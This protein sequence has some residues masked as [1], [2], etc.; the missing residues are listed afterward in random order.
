MWVCVVWGQVCGSEVRRVGLCGVRRVG[1]CVG[2]RRV[3]LCEVRCAGLFVGVRCV[4]L[5]GGQVSRS[6]FWGVRCLGLCELAAPTG[7][8]AWGLGLGSSE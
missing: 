4:G 6:V 8:M 1:L 5:W 2:V 3:G 7:P